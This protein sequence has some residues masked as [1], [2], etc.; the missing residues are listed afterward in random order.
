ML[1]AGAGK[2]GMKIACAMAAFPKLSATFMGWLKVA[3]GL[4]LD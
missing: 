3:K 1:S 4:S 2:W